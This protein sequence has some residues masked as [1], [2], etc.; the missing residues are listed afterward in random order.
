M[1]TYYIKIEASD[2][3]YRVEVSDNTPCLLEDE[4]ERVVEK[5]YGKK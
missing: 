5:F 4:I 1:S 2:H 3:Y